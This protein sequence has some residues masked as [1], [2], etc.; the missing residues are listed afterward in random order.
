MMMSKLRFSLIPFLA[1]LA[2]VWNRLGRYLVQ[3][4]W[5]TCGA[6]W[7]RGPGPL[8]GFAVL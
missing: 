8:A 4:R 3:R 5:P 1:Q 7:T 2:V 6:V